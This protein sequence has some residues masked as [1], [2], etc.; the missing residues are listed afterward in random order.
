MRK[1]FSIQVLK[2]PEKFRSV[3]PWMTW[4]FCNPCRFWGT[5]GLNQQLNQMFSGNSDNIAL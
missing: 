5:Q 4:E 3:L 1:D 2:E